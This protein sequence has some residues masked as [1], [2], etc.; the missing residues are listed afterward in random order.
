MKLDVTKIKQVPLKSTEYFKE[1]NKKTQIVLHHTAG[2]ASGVNVANDWNSDK[3]GRIATCVIISGPGARN[4]YDGEIVQCFSSKY[5]AYHLGIRSE[6][7]KAH[8]IPHRILDKTSIGIEICNWGQLDKINGKY[9]NYVNREVP[10]NQVT[11][12]TAPYKGH[13]Y[14]HRYSDAQIESTR[15]LLEYWRGIY[16]IDLSFDYTQMFSVTPKALRGEN[17]LYSHNS[18]RRDKID[19]YPCPRMIDMLIKLTK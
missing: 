16:N 17:G 19:I 14:F 7:F 11:E 5:W 10:S 15:Q 13:K 12:L 6:V 2:N 4:S 8:K 3:R 9:F 1:V 18:Y